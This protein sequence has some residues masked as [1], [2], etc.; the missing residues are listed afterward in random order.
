[1]SAYSINIAARGE[2]IVY[3]EDG[4]R[5]CFEIFLGR[6][7][8]KLYAGRSWTDSLSIV[9]R[10]LT[11]EEKQRIIPRLVRYLGSHD[12][13][14][15]VVWRESFGLQCAEASLQHLCKVPWTTVWLCRR[16]GDA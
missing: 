2:E 15:E 1:M 9:F 14:V 7:P 6:K 10:E 12:E 3:D 8:L 11:E 13:R 5:Y 4:K 16:K